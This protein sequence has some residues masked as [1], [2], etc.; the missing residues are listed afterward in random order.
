MASK[1]LRLESLKASPTPGR[2]PAEP[3]KHTAR[4]SLRVWVRVRVLVG[5][6][7]R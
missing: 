5:L 2:S 7:L 4:T 6:S 3:R 1:L